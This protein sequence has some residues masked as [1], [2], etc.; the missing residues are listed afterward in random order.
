MIEADI[1]AA[2]G[3]AWQLVAD[4]GDGD[5]LHVWLDVHFNVYELL[6]LGWR[7]YGKTAPM[8][9]SRLSGGL[10]TGQMLTRCASGATILLHYG[11]MPE[12]DVVET[13]W[14]VAADGVSVPGCRWSVRPA[15]DG[16]GGWRSD[17]DLGCRRA[18]LD[19]VHPGRRHVEG[20]GG[21]QCKAAA[22]HAFE[23]NELSAVAV[24]PE[25]VAPG[26]G[27]FLEFDSV[28]IDASPANGSEFIEWNG[29][30]ADA[31][32]HTNPLDVIMGSERHVF[33]RFGAVVSDSWK[34]HHFGSMTV[35]VDQDADA[36]GWSNREEYEADT[37][38]KTSVP[39]AATVNLSTG[40]NFIA[41]PVVPPKTADLNTLLNGLP[42]ATHWWW[43]WLDSVLSQRR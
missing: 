34:I 17:T 25:A 26:S 33:A 23:F 14:A 31:L 7:I 18:D 42:P 2:D 5:L 29:D 19:A 13:V 27:I 1:F 20:N 32:R 8:P 9:A 43:A 15:V 16:C 11:S 36:D 3:L 22:R 12:Q 30:V 24:G 28:T 40:W 6:D 37:D 38:P 10:G 39:V 41:L 4:G 21:R 35:D